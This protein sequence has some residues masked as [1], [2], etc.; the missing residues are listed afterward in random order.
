[1]VDPTVHQLVERQVE[2]TPAQTAVVFA[3]QQL[4]YRTLNQR[5]N[6]LAHHLCALGVAP[7]VPVALCL[8]RS[9]DLPVAVLAVLKAG[10][11]YVPLDPAY[12][13]E[14]LGYM[15]RDSQAPVLVAHSR[16]LSKL[17]PYAGRIVQLDTA[18]ESLTR[19]YSDNPP[20]HAQPDNLLYILYTSGSTGTPKGVAMPHRPL[21]NLVS[22]QQQTTTL[23]HPARTLQF[24]SLSFDV[25]CQELFFTLSSGG[26]LVMVD[27]DTRRDPAALWRF[28]RTADIERLFL[29][30][31]ALQHLAQAAAEDPEPPGSLREVITA[32]EALQA[33]LPVR[34]L[35]ARLEGCTLHNQYGPT[36][37]HVVASY[38]LSADPQ[39][40]EALPPIGHPIANT[41]LHIL[42]PHLHPVPVGVSGELH[43]GGTALARGYLNRA[44]LTAERFI[45]DR[46]SMVPGMRLYRTGDLARYRK[47]GSIEYLGR[48]DGQVK[49]RGYRIELGE[50][51]TVLAQCPSVRASAVAVS[52]DAGGDKRLVAYVVP[53][54]QEVPNASE[55]RAW[56]QTRLPEYMIPSAFVALERL[57]LTASGKLD[58][59]ALLHSAPE[60]PPSEQPVA[61]PRT[62]TE[63]ILA[64]IW[65]EVLGVE[66]VGI[67]DNFIALGG[68]SLLATQIVARA[69]QAFQIEVPLR[70]LLQAQTVAALASSI[71]T[72]MR[73]API[74]GSS[75]IPLATRPFKPRH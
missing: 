36:E 67:H 14:R 43:I 52:E 49:I 59:R 53:Q 25:S 37:T 71:D 72:L 16:L 1:M 45:P 38:R 6:R 8:E 48:L 56:L 51:E 21:V 40:W 50:I 9:L 4:T 35:F 44:D 63:Q 18:A 3:D 23:D 33:T 22:W 42:D 75:S 19:E 31:V 5:A 55:L 24:S 11:A 29:P 57:P 20:T 60:Q 28:L 54:A 61:A 30:F 73:A 41:T 70:T 7:E 62:A 27:E 66:Q 2:T 34:N 46:F 26:T 65:G 12:P 47:D 68:H 17:P 58:R 32:G 64:N 74:R 69:W 10:G 13:A 15:L 39:S